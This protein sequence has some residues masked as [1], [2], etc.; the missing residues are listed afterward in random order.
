[1]IAK[2]L[3]E[4]D[5]A[6]P[7]EA[8]AE[9]VRMLSGSAAGAD[10]KRAGRQWIAEAE[11]AAKGMAANDALLLLDSYYPV[12]HLTYGT[13]PDPEFVRGIIM[14]AFAARIS[15]DEGIDPY[16]LYRAVRRELRGDD[17]EAYLGKPLKWVTAMLDR[18]YCEFR[19]GVYRDPNPTRRW[20]TR[21]S[22]LSDYDLAR[23][24]E[25]L[26]SEDLWTWERNQGAFKR[27]LA[28]NYGH[29]CR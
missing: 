27:R 23:R 12:F 17:R 14:R 6:N 16:I 2:T 28:Q 26:L 15:G 3:Q 8:A 21:A 10:A 1:M 4:T 29:L 19:T 18:W 9:A 22:R 25:I 20:S 24:V 11:E 5:F 7:R 13:T